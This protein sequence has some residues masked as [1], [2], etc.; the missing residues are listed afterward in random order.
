VARPL[1]V[2]GA[3]W[4]APP[5]PGDESTRL[6]DALEL[7][8]ARYGVL[9][10]GS[11]M[12]EPQT[13]SF[14]DAY[15]LLSRMEESGATRRGYFVTGLGGA[16]FATPGA[17]D[18]LRTAPAAPMRLLAACD[19]VNPYGAAL[20]WPATNGHRPARKAGAL[21]VLDDAKPV[22][23]VERGARTLLTFTSTD[24]PRLAEA[25]RAIGAAVDAGQIGRL[26]IDKI[27]GSPA[28]QADIGDELNAAGFVMVPRGYT[29]RRRTPGSNRQE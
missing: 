16:Q 21:V 6:L 5:E 14:A 25:L 1:P 22:C 3:R 19:P 18:R 29:R 10:R 27:D 28:L 26:T 7:E 12:T 24:R 17:V 11:V 23:Y 20:E 4:A 15:R 13:P 9:T 8:L 2:G